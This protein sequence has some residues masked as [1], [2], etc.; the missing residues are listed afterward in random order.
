MY[1][2]LRARLV[3]I[4]RPVHAFP[5]SLHRMSS[6]LFSVGVRLVRDAGESERGRVNREGPHCVPHFYIRRAKA[7]FSFSMNLIVKPSI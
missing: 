5:T 1:V 7:L 3:H 2:L 6:R 4:I